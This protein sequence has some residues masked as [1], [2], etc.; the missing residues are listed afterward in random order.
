MKAKNKTIAMVEIAV[1]LFSVFLVVLPVMVIAADQCQTTQKVSA[2]TITTTSK[3]DYV[4]DIYGNANEDDTIDMRDVTYTK[5][6][7]F[8]KK[9]ETELADAYYDGEVD[10]LDVVQIKL[11]IL[12]RESELTLVD[13]ADRTVTIPKPVERIVVLWDNPPEEIRALGAIDRIVGIDTATAGIGEYYVGGPVFFPELEDVPVVGSCDNPNYEMIIDLDPDIVIQLSSWPVLPDEN[14]EILSPAGIKVVALD[15]YRVEVFYKEL[16]TLGYILD[17]EE[18]AEEYINFFQSWMDRV[19]EV[20]SN[21]DESEKKTVYFEGADKY[22]SYGGADY[23]CGVP[24]MVRAAGGIYIYDDVSPYYFEVDPEDLV[25]RNPDVIFKGTGVGDSGFSLTDTSE[26][27]EIREE[28]MNRPELQL[29]T[30][31]QN[32]DVYVIS[33]GVT[34]GARKIFGPV[35]L[36]KCLYPEKFEDMDP[37]DFIKEYLEEW[38]N[39]PYQGV[40]IY[41]YPP[42]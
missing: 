3:D 42:E 38:Q 39:L 10:V 21:L 25:N 31:V 4:L 2:S 41:P 40:Y 5:L 6:V 24:G 28:I 8:G 32:D 36:A 11:I 33:F 9:P 35:F 13:S 12:G 19:D 29:V 14:Q 30:A 37:H 34:G 18:R 15:F 16:A 1:V 7:I 27:E 17:T 20:V 26:F 23:G 22:H